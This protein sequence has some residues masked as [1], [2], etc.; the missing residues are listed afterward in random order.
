[1]ECDELSTFVGRKERRLWIWLAMDRTTR[2][3]VGCFF[4]ARDAVS[5]YGLWDSLP[6]PYLDAVCHTDRLAAYQSIVFGKYHR[7]GGTQ[8]IERFNATLRCRIAHLVRKSLS[9]S[10]KQENLETVI[11]LFIKQYNAS[12]H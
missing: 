6:L 12:L 7:I 9:F 2:K 5:A 4:G 3:I 10:R 8:H 11:H 1:M